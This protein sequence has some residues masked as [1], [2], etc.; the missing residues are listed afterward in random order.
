MDLRSSAFK[1][2]FLHG[3]FHQM[4]AAAMFGPEVFDRQRIGY[5]IGVESLPLIF[6]TDGHSFPV[7]AVATD[8][9]QLVSL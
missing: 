3:K 2:N 5:L 7:F 8:V 4:D 1:S 9:N 6:D